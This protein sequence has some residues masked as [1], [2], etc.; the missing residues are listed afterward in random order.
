MVSSAVIGHATIRE[1]WR[2]IALTM[3][4]RYARL[5][6]VADVRLVVGGG[7]I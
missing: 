5:S 4:Y 2:S 3:A 7:L 1:S 6:D